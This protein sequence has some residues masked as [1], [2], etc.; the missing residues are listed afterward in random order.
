MINENLTEYIINCDEK[1]RKNILSDSD[2]IRELD[3]KKLILNKIELPHFFFKDKYVINLIINSEVDEYRFLI[4]NLY[5][6]QSISD[7]SNLEEK[8]EKYYKS[9]LSTYDFTKKMFLKYQ[10]VF[11]LLKTKIDIFELIKNDSFNTLLPSVQY[12]IEII[13]YNQKISKPEKTKQIK[14][15]LIDLSSKEY[16]NILIDYYFK[17]VTYN[18]IMNACEII[19]FNENVKC[20]S[21]NNLQLYKI[22]VDCY[23]NNKINFDILKSLN[24]KSSYEFYED[25]RISKNKSYEMIN[26]SLKIDLKNKKNNKLSDKYGVDIYD[27]NGEEFNM[28]IHN[29][30]INK[31]NSINNV[32]DSN[33]S[34]T[35][36]SLISNKR[37]KYYNN[38]KSSIV[39]GFDNIDINNVI[40]V[41]NS[42]SYSLFI[43]GEE[44]T[45]ATNK[46]NKIYT[47]DNLIFDTFGYNEILYL[48][49]NK[50]L[51]KYVLCFDGEIKKLDIK[52][53][54]KF[55]IPIRNINTKK[56]VD[57]YKKTIIKMF[58]NSEDYV[59]NYEELK[60]KII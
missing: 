29:T 48:S 32:F 21:D 36:L 25:L 56:Y 55:N 8:R 54:K 44:E 57:R 51:P 39:I 49:D 6:R 58:D 60:A 15:L 46:L 43:K 2:I 28:L 41:Y 37:M 23:K 34:A 18:F 14:N 5:Y 30:G 20:I 35:S 40:H 38:F 19:K 16:I 47:P 9:L 53:S 50:L 42:D 33:C 12:K 26:N 7:V 17:D 31:D 24:K 13:Y 45:L 3:I 22:I 11:E 10:K 1:K 52:V 4:N 27:F 59:Q